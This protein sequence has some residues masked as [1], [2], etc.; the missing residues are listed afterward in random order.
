MLLK[1][2]KMFCLIKW[3]VVQ[4]SQRPLKISQLVDMSI[5]G[6]ICNIPLNIR[7]ILAYFLNHVRYTFSMKNFK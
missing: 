6:Y 1:R 5:I 3:F 7:Q 4:R 2:H